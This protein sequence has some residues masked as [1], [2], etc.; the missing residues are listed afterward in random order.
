MGVD[1]WN[2]RVWKVFPKKTQF[3]RGFSTSFKNPSLFGKFWLQNSKVMLK[4]ATFWCKSSFNGRHCIAHVWP[5]HIHIKTVSISIYAGFFWPIFSN[6]HQ[7]RVARLLS[8][9]QNSLSFLSKSLSFLIKILEF[10]SN[11]LHFFPNLLDNSLKFL[12]R[13]YWCCIH[14]SD[15]IRKKLLL[16]VFFALKS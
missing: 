8:F 11:I 16:K 7:L 1:L 13:S 15:T 9:G 5:K 10:F 6:H 12:K 2:I 3:T 14:Q 4:T